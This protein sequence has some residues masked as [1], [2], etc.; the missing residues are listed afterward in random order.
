MGDVREP[1]ALFAYV[2]SIATEVLNERLSPI[3][4]AKRLWQLSSEMWELPEALLT[5]VGLASEWD[6]H[7][8]DRPQREREI[9]VEMERLRR[10]FGG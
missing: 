1:E 3:D 10:R 9:M 8:P 2:T 4:G 6:D 5:F 7:P